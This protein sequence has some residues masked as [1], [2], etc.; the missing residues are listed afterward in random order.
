[1]G[2]E[3][4]PKIVQSNQKRNIYICPSRKAH[5][6]KKCIFAESVRRRLLPAIIYRKP[7]MIKRN[8]KRP[9]IGS[10][11][12]VYLNKGPIS[13]LKEINKEK[14]GETINKQQ[15][16]NERFWRSARINKLKIIFKLTLTFH[17]N[18]K[19]IEPHATDRQKT[20]KTH[21]HKTIIAHSNAKIESLFGSGHNCR[22]PS[23]QASLT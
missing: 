8:E 14:F 20:S 12:S 9:K 10:K 17:L 5:R 7:N 16:K 23:S 11:K 15:K 6:Q 21:T 13:P 19:R 22:L 18:Q 2:F 3:F 4:I 1:M